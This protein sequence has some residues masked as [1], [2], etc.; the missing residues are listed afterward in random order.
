MRKEKGPRAYK[1]QCGTPFS[2]KIPPCLLT[3]IKL[4]WMVA[5]KGQIFRRG[6][7]NMDSGE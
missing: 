4:Q 1:F 6:L 2:G 5:M 3:K 7:I